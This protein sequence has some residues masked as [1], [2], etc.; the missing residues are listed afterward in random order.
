MSFSLSRRVV[1]PLVVL[2]AL[3]L[4]PAC[5]G[6]QAGA[7]SQQSS[8]SVAG[9]GANPLTLPPRLSGDT[10]QHVFDL[11][12]GCEREYV[13]QLISGRLPA[14]VGLVN[15]THAIEGILLET[16][17]FDFEIRF[18]DTT[19]LPFSSTTQRFQ[20]EVTQGPLQLVRSIPAWTPAGGPDNPD[21]PALADGVFGTFGTVQF[22]VAGGTGVGYHAELVDRPGIDETANATGGLPQGVILS[23]PS[24]TLVG[25]PGETGPPFVFSLRIADSAGNEVFQTFQ[26]HVKVPELI[27]ATEF[28]PNGKCGESYS[29]AIDTVDGVGPF[30]FVFVET[31]VNLVPNPDDPSGP[32]IPDVVWDPIGQAEAVVNPA[33]ATDMVDATVYPAPGDPGPDYRLA[34]PGAPPEGVSMNEAQGT[35]GSG[36]APAS[37]RRRGDF[38]VF[39]YVHSTLIPNIRGQ[40]KWGQY[41]FSFQASEVAGGAGGV[42]FGQNPAYTVPGAFASSPPYAEIPEINIG[43]AY[44]PD[45]ATHPRPGL[46]ILARG[47]VPKDGKT[48]APNSSQVMTIEGLGAGEELPGS[49]DFTVD[50]DPDGVGTLQPQGV[51][52]TSH[53]GELVVQDPS[54]LQRQLHQALSFTVTDQHL[55]VGLTN[56][57]T[58]SVR[59]AIGP[60]VV[61]ITESST[62]STG[63][64]PSTVDFNDSAMQVRVLEPRTTGPVVRDL[65]DDLADGDGFYDMAATHTI[66]STAGSVT[67]STLLTGID[68]LRV[69]VNPVTWRDDPFRLNAGAARPFQHASRNN[70]YTGYPFYSI[71]S[72][73]GTGSLAPVHLASC[74]DASVVH[75]PTNGVYT[76]GGKLHVFESSTRLG[77]MIVREDARIFIPAAFTKPTYAAF[78]DGTHNPH[79]AYFDE[80]R[81]T[82]MV[83]SPNGRWAAMKLKTSVTNHFET[84]STT[85]ILLM[86]LTGTKSLGG[87]TF[88]VITTGS[89]GST[90][91]GVYQFA[92]SMVLSNRYLYYLCG[93]STAH[94]GSWRDHYIYRYETTAGA[95]GGALMTGFSAHITSANTSGTPMQT[96][97]QLFQNNPGYPSSSYI[98]S[99]SLSDTETYMREGANLHESSAAPVPFRVNALGDKVAILA[100]QHTTNTNAVDVMSHFVWV[101]DNGTLRRLTTTARHSPRGAALTG[102]LR[103]FLT[104]WTVFLKGGPSGAFE[105]SDD[106]LKVAVVVSRDTTIN[107]ALG[108][109]SDTNW[110]V[111][112][113][114]VAFSAVSGNWANGATTIQVTGNDS[115]T[116]GA[117]K[118]FDDSPTNFLWRF[119]DLSF[120]RDNNGL[121]FWGGHSAK[122]ALSNVTGFNYTWTQN[123]CYGSGFSAT[124]YYCWNNT[125]TVDV[126]A[127]TAATFA[128]S[129]FSYNFTT[130]GTRSLLAATN[131][132]PST[133]VNST[134][135]TTSNQFSPTNTAWAGNQGKIVPM[136]SFH[137]LNGNFKYVVTQGA[138]NTSDPTN[139]R[140]L[141]FNVRSLN[142]AASINTKPDGDGFVVGGQPSRRGFIGGYVPYPYYALA[143]DIYR[144]LCGMGLQVMS[145][146]GRVFYAT[147]YQSTGPLQQITATYSSSGPIHTTYY[148]DYNGYSGHVEVFDAEVGGDVQR[149]TSAVLGGDTTV[150]RPVHHIEVT[151][152]GRSAA[153]VFTA[154]SNALYTIYETI[155][156]MGG[157][158]MSP[159]GVLQPG[160]F[161]TSVQTVQG[162]VSEGVTHDS[163]GTKLF[164]GYVAGT[165]SNENGMQVYEAA[166]DSAGTMALRSVA[167]TPKRYQ[168]L[169]A[170][171]PFPPTGP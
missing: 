32:Q 53:L 24:M 62:S 86:D 106:G 33:N 98:A 102:R 59:L 49:Y 27:L 109:D 93:N 20:W 165:T 143:L 119:G 104:R 94:L 132:G 142:G 73:R 41:D 162:R 126:M 67:L 8:L 138:I 133:G 130:G 145:E 64:L 69:Y 10:V 137:S 164:H 163:A 108:G 57:E 88:R 21:Y 140:L 50:W 101:D 55:P 70:Y 96:P 87:Q 167:A 149:V 95:A 74:T 54:L 158:N 22:V 103:G 38:R 71:S 111:R 39:V 136:G 3:V 6:S 92:A 2:S 60:D 91:Q 46:Q 116:I 61:I 19:C 30:R 99:T 139:W 123:S 168:M 12:G 16:G 18:T 148:G 4:A 36:P 81:I 5:G 44:D 105:I 78:G 121:L 129:Y 154:Q 42:P 76:D 82:H 151:N 77:V 72:I 34:F 128:G 37:P 113:D 122:N 97:F 160:N 120:T 63:T 52:F 15:A 1:A 135:Y 150:F 171:R 80:T 107:G 7:L 147:H 28:L 125:S 66:P 90:T 40:R 166:F 25:T 45:N 51:G 68:F 31:M 43:L 114:V 110:D 124:T 23:E 152:D 56:S 155:V 159:S 131:G 141:G 17:S 26:W 13:L 169:H 29:T 48:D 89:N 134:P 144:P 79:G 146:N 156:H 161:M 47:G 58:Q 14:G 153:V 100:G 35:I 11:V 127:N 85:R 117:A 115:A 112:E 84:A 170:S 118:V 9:G 83:V 75:D 65:D 157:I